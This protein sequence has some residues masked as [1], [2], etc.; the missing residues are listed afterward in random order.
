MAEPGY[1]LTF[2]THRLHRSPYTIEPQAPSASASVSAFEH[3]LGVAN[4][5]AGA[6]VTHCALKSRMPTPAGWPGMEWLKALRTSAF[7]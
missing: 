5:D 3:P 4:A 6:G 2:D 1:L 7:G